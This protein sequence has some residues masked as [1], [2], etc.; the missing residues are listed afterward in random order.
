MVANCLLFLLLT[1][2]FCRP[3]LCGQIHDAAQSGDLAQ[4]KELLKENPDLVLSKDTPGWTAL[5]YAAYYGR[6]D[7]AELL[8][9]KNADVNTKDNQGLT[10]LHLAAKEGHKDTAEVLLTNKADVNAKDN[11]GHT[12]LHFAAIYGYKD[13]I[14]LLL[15]SKAALDNIHDAA[16][17]GALEAVKL[18]LGQN[19][20][21]VM[22]KDSEGKTPL[23]Y[24][25]L[26]GHKDVVE[27]LLNYKADINVK[28]KDGYTPLYEAAKGGHKE[29]A[30][31][32]LTK[33]ADVNAKDNKG[34]SPL[35]EAVVAD[36]KSVVE[37]LLLN[38]ADVNA[39]DT[40]NRQTP[41]HLAAWNGRKNVAQ[42][43]L[44]HNADMNAKNQYGETP[45]DMALSLA[46]P[47]GRHL[48]VAEL[49]LPSKVDIDTVIAS[50]KTRLMIAAENGDNDLVDLL[51]THMANKTIKSSDGKTALDYANGKL[52]ELK[53]LQVE[54]IDANTVKITDGFAYQRDIVLE[55]PSEIRITGFLGNLMMTEGVVPTG[56][57]SA[58][59]MTWVFTKPNL[60]LHN[61]DNIYTS[62]TNHASIRF[63]KEGVILKSFKIETPKEEGIRK[64]IKT[65]AN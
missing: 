39:I 35:H 3:A 61:G 59:G 33:K 64:V 17:V 2:L 55:S 49:L 58:V 45:L 28:D 1:A 21:L 53:S 11:N 26:N 42:L 48:D 46:A 13:V 29:V 54:K 37:L 62:L 47:G 24:A 52:S 27:L 25:V 36:D 32:L 22:S 16:A 6:K 19:P 4:V 51:V 12:A 43:L 65:V 50:G 14:D 31:L 10:P 63:T 7:V 18:L 15:A 60:V 38:K 8:L 23:H 9:N 57:Q 56:G 5:H 41:L 40:N 30:E 20:D 34:Y 44:A